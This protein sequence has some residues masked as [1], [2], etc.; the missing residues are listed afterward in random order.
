MPESRAS[1]FR[2]FWSA[3]GGFEENQFRSAR[4]FVA[5]DLLKAEDGFVKA[6]ALLEVVKPVAGVEQFANV[7]RR[8]A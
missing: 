2:R 5:A 1:S 8:E 7:H 4:G 6:D 3:A